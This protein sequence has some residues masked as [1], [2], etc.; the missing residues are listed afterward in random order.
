[1]QRKKYVEKRGAFTRTVRNA[2]RNYEN[3]KCA[4]VERLAKRPG[5]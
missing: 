2:K 1:V 3:Q 5:E 4:E